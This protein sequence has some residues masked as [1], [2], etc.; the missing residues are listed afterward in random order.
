MFEVFYFIYL[1]IILIFK[2]D[3]LYNGKGNNVE[4]EVKEKIEKCLIVICIVSYIFVDIFMLCSLVL[5]NNCFF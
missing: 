4:E 2:D 3:N 1:I 5:C